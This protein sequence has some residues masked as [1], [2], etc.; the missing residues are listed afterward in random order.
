MRIRSAL[1]GLV[2]ALTLP[3][4]AQLSREAIWARHDQLVLATAAPLK[5]QAEWEHTFTGTRGQRVRGYDLGPAQAPAVLWWNGGPG[6]AFDPSIVTG[7]LR[8]PSAFRVLVLDQPGV[9]AGAS[10]WVPGWKPEDT[11]EDAVTFLK[12]RG[13][14][15]PVI[16]AGWSWGSTMALL[17][18]QRHPE[19][20]RGVAVGGIWSNTPQEVARYLG[21]EGTHALM[22]GM[23]EAFRA[24]ARPTASAC[25]LHDALKRGVGGKALVEAYDRAE[26]LQSVATTSLREEVLA[27]VAASAGTPVDMVSEKDPN[28]RFAYIE[29]EMM[30]RGQRGEWALKM[31]FPKTLEPVP[32]VVVQG[33]FDQV[34]DPE[35]A[36]QVHRAWPGARKIFIPLNTSHGSNRPPTD[37]QL[38]A[39]G[40]DPALRP[41]IARALNLETG[42]CG[43]MLGAAVFALHAETTSVQ[44]VEHK[45]IK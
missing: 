27:P 23:A 20:C 9:G 39:A 30:C 15:G 34:C 10:E 33:R 2:T 3:L 12:Q 8:D 41:Q 42:A 1:F 11:V 35:V 5:A 37:A 18:A 13:I 14:R 29:S 4:S 21:P 36:L 43:P 31:D 22:P 19:L 6:S 26:S 25:D 7:C 24:V 40:L 17:F 16:V 38:K 28:T 32:L 45:A 44:D